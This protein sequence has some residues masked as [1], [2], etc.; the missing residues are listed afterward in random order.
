M[1]TRQAGGIALVL[2]VISAFMMVVFHSIELIEERSSLNELHG[3]QDNAV[4]EALTLRRQF[5]ALA[6][7]VSG[8]AASGDSSAQAVLDELQKQGITLS[9]VKR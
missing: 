6:A 4:R 8:L 2:L 9:A 1:T 7:G 3:L 5:E